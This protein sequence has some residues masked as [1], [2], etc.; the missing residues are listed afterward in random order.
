MIWILISLYLIVSLFV[1]AL[2]FGAGV[3]NNG[4]SEGEHILKTIALSFAIGMTW[5]VLLPI[6]AINSL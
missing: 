2:V 4:I 1:G 5:P 6:I 3:A